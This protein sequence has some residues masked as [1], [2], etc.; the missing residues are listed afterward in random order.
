MLFS[1]ELVKH[2]VCKKQIEPRDEKQILH[3]IVKSVEI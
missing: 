2:I 1:I 3:N